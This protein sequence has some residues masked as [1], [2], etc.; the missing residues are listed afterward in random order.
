MIS[1]RRGVGDQGDRM[2]TRRDLLSLVVLALTAPISVFA[3]KEKTSY[4]VGVLRYSGRD[5]NVPYIAAFKQGLESFGYIEGNNLTLHIRYADGEAERLG[6]LAE[7]LVRLKVDIIMAMDTLSTRAAQRASTVIPIVIGTA[8]DPVGNGLVASL[9]RPGGNTTGLSN[10]ASDIVPK[11]LELLVAILPKITRVAV[12]VNSAN[13]ASRPE[14]KAIEEASK[15]VGLKLITLEVNRPAQI[16]QAFSAMTQQRVEGLI[17]S[18]DP[19]LSQQRNLIASL[20]LKNR[21]LAIGGTLLY[22]EAGMLI[23][24][25][26]N[27]SE[28]YRRAATYVDKILKGA[29]AGDLPVEQPTT[30][31]LVVN[32][33]TAK[34]LGIKFPQS[35]LVQATTVIE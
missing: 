35:I 9:A 31:E 33:K 24:Y 2:I 26:Q 4:I 27:V 17:V 21:I 20:A 29:K 18:L 23:S 13:P 6:P 14:L 15:R 5:S 16:E 34:A 30:I 19:M 32:N 28:S 11:R 3:Q 12:L 8:T 25:G 1:R 7:E 22:A 10:M